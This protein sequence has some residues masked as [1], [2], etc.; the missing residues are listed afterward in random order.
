MTL[1]FIIIIFNDKAAFI[2]YILVSQA[3][4]RNQHKLSAVYMVQGSST[5]LT[6][7]L[8]ISLIFYYK[9][10]ARAWAFTHSY[11]ET[12]DLLQVGAL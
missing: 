3:A 5:P 12:S 1:F 9:S 4:C 11:L 7:V 10:G 2:K 8:L 6:L